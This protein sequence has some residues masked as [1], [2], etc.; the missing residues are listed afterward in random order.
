MQ[1]P[2]EYNP[3][4]LRVKAIWSG[5]QTGADYGGLLAGEEL[6]LETGGW[7][8]RDFRTERGPNLELK[9]RFGLKET[10]P[11]GYRTRTIRNIR[12]TD[13]TIIFGKITS[14]GSKLTL[15]VCQKQIKPILQVPYPILPFMGRATVISVQVFLR[16]NKVTRLNVA[17][18]RESKNRGI[19][20]Y[21]KNL[22]I[23][24]LTEENE[25][26]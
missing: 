14:P 10:R 1:L 21:V 20:D 12:D 16:E 7:A 4:A 22:L 25:D 15:K 5:G 8:P 18:N 9:E 24:A 19:Q 2:E 26:V 3:N 6:G 17:G 13:A 11:I 23:A